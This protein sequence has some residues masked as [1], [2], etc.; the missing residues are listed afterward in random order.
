MSKTPLLGVMTVAGEVA[1]AVAGQA[2]AEMAIEPEVVKWKEV[3]VMAE[4][5]K[6]EGVVVM[7]EEGTG[8]EVEETDRAELWVRVEGEDR[9]CMSP[10]CRLYEMISHL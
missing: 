6:W 1:T 3:V 7:A 2:M 4:V 8:M 10:M 5:V 9:E